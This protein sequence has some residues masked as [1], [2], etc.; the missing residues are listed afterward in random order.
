[1][2]R[3]FWIEE[4]DPAEV[5]RQKVLAGVAQIDSG[6]E[7]TLPYALYMLGV[8]AADDPV[9]RMNPQL[10]RVET[11]DALRQLLL[12]AAE[13]RPQVMV[14]EDLHWSDHATR[15]FLTFLID[16]I[17]RSRVLILVTLRP[18]HDLSLAERTYSTRLVVHI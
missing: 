2:R 17:P 3:N 11:F 18:G 4:Q 15:E 10:R 1:M 13:R 12:R 5:V 14:Y 8:A 7:P 6:L 9:H 16:S